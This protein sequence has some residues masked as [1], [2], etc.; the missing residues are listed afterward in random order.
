MTKSRNQ[1]KIH[2]AKWSHWEFSAQQNVTLV[3]GVLFWFMS[4]LHRGGW[5]CPTNLEEKWHKKVI[6]WGQDFVHFVLNGDNCKTVESLWPS[7]CVF[8]MSR[9]SCFCASITFSRGFYFPATTEG[10]SAATFTG[11]CLQGRFQC[12]QK[13]AE[14]FLVRFFF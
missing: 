2:V 12:N 14:Y 3:T 1:K 6:I 8:R 9:C 13:K 11:M 4:D 5:T 7:W 10:L